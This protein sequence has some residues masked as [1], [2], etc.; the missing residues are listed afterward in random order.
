MSKNCS[1][2][3]SEKNT[4][5]RIIGARPGTV[6]KRKRCQPLAPSIAAAS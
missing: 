6:M 2:P 1:E 4:E 3:S 5:S